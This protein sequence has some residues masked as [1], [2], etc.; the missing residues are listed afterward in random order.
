MIKTW[1]E[2]KNL[3]KLAIEIQKVMEKKK[4]IKRIKK[5]G[6][7][8]ALMYEPPLPQNLYLVV[9]LRFRFFVV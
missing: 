8:A 1:K 9:C 7:A 2:I 6:G 3:K 5:L 4:K